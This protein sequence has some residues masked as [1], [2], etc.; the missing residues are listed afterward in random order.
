MNYQ[1]ILSGFGAQEILDAS[2]GTVVLASLRNTPAND[3][4]QMNEGR[5]V[6]SEL[7]PNGTNDGKNKTVS[8]D[9]LWTC[10]VP[11]NAPEATFPGRVAP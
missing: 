9:W 3:L 5:F 4:T 1:R 10:P 11:T 7:G 8:D 2:G 6:L